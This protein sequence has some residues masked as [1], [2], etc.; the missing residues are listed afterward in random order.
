MAIYLGIDSG[1]AAPGFAVVDAGDGHDKVLHGSCFH[2]KGLTEK[3]RDKKDVY[4]SDDD[5]RRCVRI[6]DEIEKLVRA[7]KPDL[8]I[9]EL[10]SAGARD[11]AAIKGMALGAATTVVTLHRLGVPARYIS[12]AENK[13]G[14]AGAPDAEKDDVLAAVK[15]AWPDFAGW[16]MKKTKATEPDLD[17]CYA[18]ADALSCVLTHLEGG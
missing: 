5:A 8:A 17:D 7:H 4:K 15:K 14:S 3:Q 16:P 13:R 10:P 6:S 11:A 18:V 1:F 9:V 12:P 2:T